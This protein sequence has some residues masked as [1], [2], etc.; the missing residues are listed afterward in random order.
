LSRKYKLE[1]DNAVDGASELKKMKKEEE[2]PEIKAEV[3]KQNEITYKYS[4]E[5]EKNLTK[6]EL[7]AL[8]ELPRTGR[9]AHH[10]QG[11]KKW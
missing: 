4:D 11:I 5:L 10:S 6:D 3:K 1:P 8:I 9:G 2:G 7:T